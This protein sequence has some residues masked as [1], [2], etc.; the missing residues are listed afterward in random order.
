M[1]KTIKSALIASTLI[2]AGAALADATMGD[3]AHKGM[4]PGAHMGMHHQPVDIAKLLN[5]DA[6]R[7]AQVNTILTDE[8]A[9]RKALWEANK[10]TAHD[11]AGKTAFRTQMKALREATKARLTAVLTAEELQKL[12]DSMPHGGPGAHGMKQG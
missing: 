3:G 6:T 7:T 5:L 9:Q 1:K 12:R 10:G 4:G 8:R 11:E 2:V